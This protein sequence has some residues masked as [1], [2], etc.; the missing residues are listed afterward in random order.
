MTNSTF[1]WSTNN[2]T[3]HSVI[4][5][6]LD[7]VCAQ[8]NNPDNLLLLV[9]LSALMMRMCRTDCSPVWWGVGWSWSV[10]KKTLF[11]IEL[12]VPW[13]DAV[14]EAHKHKKLKRSNPVSE[15]EQKCWWAQVLP[16]DWAA[17]VLR[18][19]QAPGCWKGWES[20]DRL[21]WGSCF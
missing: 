5:F 19:R 3:Q 17:G 13:E 4:A 20:D 8:I 14:G 21:S 1:T 7:M 9:I 18:P 10:S 12:T 6:G 16:M 2:L 11:I 15:A